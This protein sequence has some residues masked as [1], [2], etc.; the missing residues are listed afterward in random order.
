MICASPTCWH[1]HADPLV[2]VRGSAA[3]DA[4]VETSPWETGTVGD[5][6]IPAKKR[7]FLELFG[8]VP[9]SP[10][11]QAKGLGDAVKSALQRNLT[12]TPGT[13]DNDKAYFRGFVEGRTHRHRRRVR[14]GHEGPCRV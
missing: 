8:A 4:V 14:Q 11:W 7:G 6:K 5:G 10:D 9:G 1:L 3:S 2:T 13:T 12:Y